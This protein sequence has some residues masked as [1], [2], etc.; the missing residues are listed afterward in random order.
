MTIFLHPQLEKHLKKPTN[1]LYRLEKQSWWR[2]QSVSEYVPMNQLHLG[3]RR[4]SNP[5]LTHTEALTLRAILA[6]AVAVT[7]DRCVRVVEER[8]GWFIEGHPNCLLHRQSPAET[9]P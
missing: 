5:S 1:H 8:R 9:L 7:R 3:K 2:E 6:E 4:R